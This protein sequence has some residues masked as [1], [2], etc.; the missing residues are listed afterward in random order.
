LIKVLDLFLWHLILVLAFGV[1]GFVVKG[2]AP[3]IKQ[4]GI[5]MAGGFFPYF[6]S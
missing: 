1:L 4:L 3:L 2:A 5:E 6:S